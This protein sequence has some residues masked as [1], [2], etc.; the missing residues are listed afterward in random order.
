MLIHPFKLKDEENQLTLLPPKSQIRALI[1]KP[2]SEFKNLSL[3]LHA[4]FKDGLFH[5]RVSFICW[6]F[7]LVTKASIQKPAWSIWGDVL[8]PRL[9]SANTEDVR[10]RPP[11]RWAL[12]LSRYEDSKW[13][14]VPFGREQNLKIKRKNNPCCSRLIKDF[15]LSILNCV[16][17]PTVQLFLAR[18][19]DPS[20]ELQDSACTLVFLPSGSGQRIGQHPHSIQTAGTANHLLFINTCENIFLKT[21][22]C[23]TYYFVTHTIF[24]HFKTKCYVFRRNYLV[25]FLWSLHLIRLLV[26]LICRILVKWKWIATIQNP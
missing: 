8:T 9:L 24:T 19:N 16:I 7:V 10:Q 21:A 12:Y 1:L 4:G 6:R 11:G 18:I 3:W 14:L 23:Y 26:K 5:F 25:C 22:L 15:G 13:P 17:V 20:N 2:L